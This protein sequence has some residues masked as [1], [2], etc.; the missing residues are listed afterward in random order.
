MCTMYTRACVSVFLLSLLDNS[1]QALP[2]LASADYVEKEIKTHREEEEEAE[3]KTHKKYQLYKV[4]CYDK[5]I[6]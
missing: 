5:N 2:A 1:M 4:Y 3:E 6:S